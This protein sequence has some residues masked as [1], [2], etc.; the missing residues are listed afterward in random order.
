MSKVLAIAMQVQN[1]KFLYARRVLQETKIMKKLLLVQMLPGAKAWMT[2]L[3]KDGQS[4]DDS[5]LQRWWHR[6]N[7]YDKLFVQ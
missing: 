7:E 5:P 4:M 1:A 6:R 3:Y 2:V